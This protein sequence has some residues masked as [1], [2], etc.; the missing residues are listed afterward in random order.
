M[1]GSEPKVSWSPSRSK[2]LL[3]VSGHQ[4]WI[5]LMHSTFKHNTCTKSDQRKQHP[6]FPTARREDSDLSHNWYKTKTKQ[7]LSDW[8]LKR[9]GQ[10]LQ[11]LL[12]SKCECRMPVPGKICATHIIALSEALMLDQSGLVT[13]PGYKNKSPLILTCPSGSVGIC[14]ITVTDQN[15]QSESH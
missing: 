10:G 14:L 2:W 12:E 3:S 15:S 13:N 1:S 5:A 8:L 6:C 9:S 11:V 7:K 4:R